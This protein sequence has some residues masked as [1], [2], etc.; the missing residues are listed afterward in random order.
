MHNQWLKVSTHINSCF[1]YPHP[2]FPFDVRSILWHYCPF[3]PRNASYAIPKRE[4]QKTTR[5]P[6]I[7]HIDASN[8]LQNQWKVAAFWR[9]N[10]RKIAAWENHNRV[11]HSSSHLH[12]KL[13]KLSR[14][15]LNFSILIIHS[16][17]IMIWSM[18]LS[19]LLTKKYHNQ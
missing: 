18:Q 8:I 1:P 9:N 4:N 3:G 5:Q 19:L 13:T 6:Q 11:A 14:D 10:K 16:C 15:C 12:Q 2:N 17:D 7:K